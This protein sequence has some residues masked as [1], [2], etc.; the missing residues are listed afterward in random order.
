MRP[1]DGIYSGTVAAGSGEAVANRIY[2]RTSQRF[3]N[4]SIVD[5]PCREVGERTLEIHPRLL[6]W[7]DRA[8]NWSGVSDKITVE[9]QL[10]DLP[11]N[12]T[13][14]STFQAASTWFTFVNAPPEDLLDRT[15]DEAIDDLLP[16]PAGG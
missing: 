5:E 7:E 14:R 10:R 6:H 1:D 11:A 16:P 4:V 13:R 8:T 9:L 2:Q 15:F 3:S 12:G